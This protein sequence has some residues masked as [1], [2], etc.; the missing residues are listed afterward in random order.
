MS[1]GRT[2]LFRGITSRLN[3]DNIDTDTIIPKQ[4]LTVTDKLGLGQFLFYYWRAD[5]NLRHHFF[6]LKRNNAKA[7]VLLVKTNFG[8]G[9]SREHAPW[10]LKQS[11]LSV[12]IGL[13]FA[14]IFYANCIRNGVLPII[15]GKTPS[16]SRFK[17][18]ESYNRKMIVV[19][20][21]SKK[22]IMNPNSTWEFHLSPFYRVS[23]LRGLTGIK[24]ILKSI[25]EIAFF[26]SKLKTLY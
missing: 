3:K 7:S 2:I 25:N 4:F 8:C 11:G 9:S 10:A 6:M 19:N 24:L 13:S 12:I 22:V 21:L 16:L 20:L 15:L 26:E 17:I 1:F 18:L 5:T 23:L 14:E